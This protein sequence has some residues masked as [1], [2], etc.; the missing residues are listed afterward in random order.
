MIPIVILICKEL[1]GH[2]NA[3]FLRETGDD[4]PLELT[5]FNLMCILCILATFSHPHS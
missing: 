1:S 4:A 2:T 3:N 5:Q